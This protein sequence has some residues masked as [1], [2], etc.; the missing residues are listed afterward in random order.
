MPDMHFWCDWAQ[1][2]TLHPFPHA[3]HMIGFPA[4]LSGQLQLTTPHW[5]QLHHYHPLIKSRPVATVF[6]PFGKDSL[7]TMRRALT[8]PYQSLRLQ[9][10][11]PT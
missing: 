11:F 7:L 2:S 10:L 5:H 6:L 8:Y 3:F 1:S 9:S 4:N